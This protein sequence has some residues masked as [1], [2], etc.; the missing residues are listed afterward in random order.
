[1]H[2]YHTI[3]I[4][5]AGTMGRGIARLALQSG[6]TVV[7]VDNDDRALETARNFFTKLGISRRS[8]FLISITSN[9]C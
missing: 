1:M 4:V 8:G 7:L 5:G 3:G 2:Q 9:S 6:M